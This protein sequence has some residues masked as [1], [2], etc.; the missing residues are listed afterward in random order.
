MALIQSVIGSIPIYFLS[1]FKI[2]TKPA[3]MIEK[4]TRDFFWERK[5]ER[6]RDHLIRWDTVS[7]YKKCGGFG[8]GNLI[9]KKKLALF[10]K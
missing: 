7:R 4:M 2:P 6:K 9:K 10:G 1:I 8:V 5:G 3:L